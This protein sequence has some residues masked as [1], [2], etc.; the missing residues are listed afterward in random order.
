MVLIQIH[1]VY[2]L[3]RQIY[4]GSS[5]GI[6]NQFG[7]LAVNLSMQTIWA[8]TKILVAGEARFSELE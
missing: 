1:C 7:N 3:V 4:I 2:V 8:C 5:L 6:G